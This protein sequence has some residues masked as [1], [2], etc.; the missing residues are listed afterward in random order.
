MSTG[1]SSRTRQFDGS[2]IDEVRSPILIV[3]DDDDIRA[4]LQRV[5]ESAGYP[6]IQAA[7][8]R[9]ALTTARRQ[10]PG[11]VLLDL[12]MP[13]MDGWDFL[14]EWQR[15]PEMASIPV[16]VISAPL[17]GPR[18]MPSGV[19]GYLSKPFDADEL[20]KLVSGLYRG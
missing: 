8:G 15:D 6:T 1:G 16:L 3:D 11:L 14:L 2:I 9:E 20:L 10:P 17:K 19:N 12:M 5:L 18:G 13:V 4:A 7:D